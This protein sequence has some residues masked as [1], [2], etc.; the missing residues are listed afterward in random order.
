[1][2][3]S[4]PEI[5]QAFAQATRQVM[6]SACGADSQVVFIPELARARGPTLEGAILEG[7]VRLDGD[8][9]QGRMLLIFSEWVY[10]SYLNAW[11]G[12]KIEKVSADCLDGV[13]EFTNLIFGAAKVELNQ[14]GYGLKKSLPQVVTLESNSTLSP[15]REKICGKP[16]AYG[17][18]RPW[19]LLRSSFLLIR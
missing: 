6:K 7:S 8:F 1:M 4:L 14:K 10:L 18:I 13:G 2:K 19:V 3:V 15:D 5:S 9:V 12:E 16:P 11:T 17:W